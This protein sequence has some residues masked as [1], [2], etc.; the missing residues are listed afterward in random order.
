M[1]RQYGAH[2]TKIVPTPLSAEETR[3]IAS[4]LLLGG[5]RPAALA[6]TILSKSE[7]NP[8][9]VEEFVRTLMNKGLLV[10]AGDPGTLAITNSLQALLTARVDRID[11]ETKNTLQLASVIGRSFGYRVLERISDPAMALDRHSVA[12]LRADLLD[13]AARH[14]ELEM[15]F[16]YEHDNRLAYHL[17]EA[18]DD[19][20]AS[21]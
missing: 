12:L 13:E 18:G 17:A 21:W 11:Q 2:Y 16:K 4:R 9:L 14:P 19:E 5:D 10:R 6:R 7:G 8:L 20:K 3:D 1:A 15:V